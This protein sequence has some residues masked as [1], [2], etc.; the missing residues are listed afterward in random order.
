MT[1]VEALEREVEKLSPEELAAFRAWFAEYDWQAW[2]RELARDVAAGRLDKFAD[3]A[4][5]EHERGETREI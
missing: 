1:N 2:D 4:L 3:E 5:A